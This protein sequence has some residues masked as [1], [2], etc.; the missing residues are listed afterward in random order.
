MYNNNNGGLT[1]PSPPSDYNDRDGPTKRHLNNSAARKPVQPTVAVLTFTVLLCVFSC[2]LTV[3]L[4]YKWHADAGRQINVLLDVVEE[5][6]CDLK[7]LTVIIRNELVAKRI[8]KDD[9]DDD[10]GQKNDGHGGSGTTAK[11]N[12]EYDESDEDEDYKTD[13]FMGRDLSDNNWPTATFRGYAT[14]ASGERSGVATEGRR[15]RRTAE[16]DAKR[17]AAKNQLNG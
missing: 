3:A 17:S 6:T 15:R 12:T 8:R 10:D 5:V 1:S 9:D 4:S 11:S 7:R 13:N 2:S 16:V 14:T